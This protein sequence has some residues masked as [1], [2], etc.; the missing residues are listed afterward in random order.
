[1]SVNSTDDESRYVLA[2]IAAVLVAVALSM[3][4]HD[5]CLIQSPEIPH[6]GGSLGSP[7]PIEE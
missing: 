7:T 5:R 3:V 1:M 4:A 2:A 6:F